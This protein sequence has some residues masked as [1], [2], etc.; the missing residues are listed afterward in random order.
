MQV[1]DAMARTPNL[2]D[3]IQAIPDW[4]LM[5]SSQ[6]FEV[7]SAKTIQYRDD[8]EW[9]WQGIGL[10]IVQETG[11]RFGR[12]GCKKLQ[13]ALLAAGELLWVSQI[14]AGMSLT[15]AEI[16]GVLRHL[17]QTGVV[18]G[19]RHVADAVLRKINLLEQHGITTTLEAVAEAQSYLKIKKYCK[20]KVDHYENRLIAYREKM[21][22]YDGTGPE[23]DF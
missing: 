7:L 3:L 14:S 12:D 11:Q 23:P 15:D 4:D 9:T 20:G 8:S 21:D 17:D 5:S 6:V 2:F 10:V 18:P 22:I 19:A 16:Q 1:G 13:D